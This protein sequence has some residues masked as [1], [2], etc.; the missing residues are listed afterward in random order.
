MLSHSSAAMHTEQCPWDPETVFLPTHQGPLRGDP[1]APY[2]TLLGA[3]VLQESPRGRP[4]I[5]LHAGPL[6]VSELLLSADN[7]GQPEL[8]GRTPNR[9]NPGLCLPEAS[10]AYYRKSLQSKLFPT[11]GPLH[12]PF[13]LPSTSFTRLSPGKLIFQSS[14]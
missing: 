9:H 4:P 10:L 2:T 3:H 14:V 1:L 12:V 5:L 11:P 13:S 8:A 6:S 7:T